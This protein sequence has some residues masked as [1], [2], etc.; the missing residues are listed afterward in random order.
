MVFLDDVDMY[1]AGAREA[2]ILAVH[3]RDNTQAIEEIEKLRSPGH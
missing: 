1:V 3:Y 2:G